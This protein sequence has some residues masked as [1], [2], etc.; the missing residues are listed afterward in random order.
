MQLQSGWYNEQAAS[1]MIQEVWLWLWQ[2]KIFLFF[3]A[4]VLI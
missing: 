3:K 1:D 2:G 4:L